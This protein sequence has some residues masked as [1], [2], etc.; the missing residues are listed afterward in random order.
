MTS[1]PQPQITIRMY[2]MGFGDAFLVSVGRTKPWRMLIDCGVHNSGR[3]PVA[4]GT[5]VGHII[6]DLRPRGGGDPHVD[7]VVATHHHADHIAGFADP[8]WDRVHVGEVWLPWVEDPHDDQARRLRADLAAAAERVAGLA[9]ELGASAGRKRK[10]GALATATA[11]AEN[12]KGNDIATDRLVGNTDG[13]VDPANVRFLPRAGETTRIEIADLAVAHVMGPSRDE[14]MLKRMAPPRKAE[15]L[16]DMAIDGASGRVPL[17]DPRYVLDEEVMKEPRLRP[18]AMHPRVRDD[19][20]RLAD[21]TVL[22][23]ASKLE[24][25]CNNTSLFLVLEVG[26]RRLVFPGDAQQGAWDF[27]LQS[28]ENV[29]LLTGADFYKISHHGSHNGTPRRFVEEILGDDRI[30]MLP[31]SP[32]DQWPNI[33]K[34]TLLQ[35]LGEHGHRILRSDEPRRSKGVRI[36]PDGNWTQLQ[37]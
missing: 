23:G 6:D 19:L 4:L 7:V 8:A 12:A 21:D 11:L 29:E 31:F 28:P 10:A 37:L 20:R 17:F 22:F 9:S 5:M 34:S 33:P 30:T 27:V 15:W 24:R 18:L 14:G 1:P 36:G 2:R 35:G 16:A 25:W 13:F 26:E 3:G 32:V